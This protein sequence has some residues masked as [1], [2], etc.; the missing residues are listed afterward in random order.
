MNKKAYI[1]TG[2]LGS[3]KTTSMVRSI[4]EFFKNKKVVIIVNEFGEVSIDGKVLSAELQNQGVLELNQGCICCVLYDELNKVLTDIQSKY[5]FDYLFIET[6]GLSEPFPIYS[7]LVSLGYN[8]ES[9][10]CLIDSLNYEKYKDDDVFK[11]QIGSANIIVLNKIDL[12][13]QSK[14]E[15]L[16]KEIASLKDKYNLKNLLTGEYLIPK[17]ELITTT[18]GRIPEYIFTDIDLPIS[19]DL[20]LI[21]DEHS[22]KDYVKKVDYYQN[23]ALYYDQF[24]KIVKSFPKNLIRSKG[25]LKF[26]DV[27]TP[28]LFNY[29]YGNYTFEEFPGKID[30]GVLVSIFLNELK[31]LSFKS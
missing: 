5:D 15:S 23:D 30:K 7:A 24:I 6:S 2:Y 25:I 28:L 22:H 16:K 9:V 26:K 18:Y 3:G 1:F 20:S 4:E 14:I 11:Y 31:I 29:T 12:I 8:V 27:D 17:Y 10:I 19:M 13:E 21:K